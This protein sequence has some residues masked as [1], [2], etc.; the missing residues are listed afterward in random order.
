MPKKI[1]YPKNTKEVIQRIIEDSNRLKSMQE[2]AFERWSNSKEGEES[3]KIMFS[4]P[5]GVISEAISDFAHGEIK[6][7][8]LVPLFVERLEISE[9][10]AQKIK[11]ILS[12]EIFPL[13]SS[14]GGKKSKSV[15]S[16]GEKKTK[17]EKD[18]Y[19]EPIT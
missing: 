19:R 5:G 8:D 2:K 17:K 14:S 9:K 10:R 11:K 3:E 16:E 1:I 12:T 15:S 7:E 6:K 13:L 18:P 4:S